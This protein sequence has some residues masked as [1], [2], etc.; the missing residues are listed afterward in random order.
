MTSR[1]VHDTATLGGVAEEK[2]H[3]KG[4][5]IGSLTR[6]VEGVRYWPQAD[7]KPRTAQRGK[8]RVFEDYATIHRLQDEPLHSMFAD[9]S[10]KP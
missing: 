4:H 9:V 8:S 1:G 2:D 10:I 3:Y 5:L 6:Q 7:V